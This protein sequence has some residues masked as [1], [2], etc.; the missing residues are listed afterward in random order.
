MYCHNIK[1]IYAFKIWRLFPFLHFCFLLRKVNNWTVTAEDNFLHFAEE[2]WND[3]FC[4]PLWIF[5]CAASPLPT[6]RGPP[7]PKAW[8]LYSQALSV[9]ACGKSTGD[10]SQELIWAC[11]GCLGSEYSIGFP[12]EDS[13][14]ARPTC[15]GSFIG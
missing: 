13:L 12:D 4:E 9:E 2:K 6:H 11:L 7:S 3:V 5:P 1:L 15:S 10:T 8:R 14:P